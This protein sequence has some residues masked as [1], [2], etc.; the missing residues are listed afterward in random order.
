M[1]IIKFILLAI[2]LVIVAGF[3]F[4]AVVDMPVTQDTVQVEIPSGTIFNDQ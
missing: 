2:P 4:F 3:V 1:D